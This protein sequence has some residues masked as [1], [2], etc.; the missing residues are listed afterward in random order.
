MDFLPLM[1]TDARAARNVLMIIEE[2]NV[3]QTQIYNSMV[4][5][6]YNYHGITIIKHFHNTEILFK[7]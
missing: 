7:A 3:L 1:K 6:H 2:L 4:E 5:G